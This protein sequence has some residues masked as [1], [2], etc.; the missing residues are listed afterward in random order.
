MSDRKIV[1]FPL[2]HRDRFDQN[3]PP[4]LVSDMDDLGERGRGMVVFA[5]I[6]D[7]AEDILVH[8]LAANAIKA[9]VDLR[10]CPVFERP[11]FRHKNVVFHLYH[12]GIPYVEMAMLAIWPASDR[13]LGTF[14]REQTYSS[15]EPAM[16]LG[17]TLCIYDKDARE[18]GWLEET[19]RMIRHSKTFVAELHPHALAGITR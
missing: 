17:L 11:R 12:Q 10:P 7:F 6:D 2:P 19:R 5:D 4:C 8:V 14:D 15:I 13:R 1:R 18:A 16:D 9:V 3:P